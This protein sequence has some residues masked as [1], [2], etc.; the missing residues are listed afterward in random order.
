MLRKWEY[1]AKRLEGEGYPQELIKIAQEF[2]SFLV[3][4]YPDE[5]TRPWQDEYAA[6][7][8]WSLERVAA[9]TEYCVACMIEKECFLCKFGKKFGHCISEGS[10]FGKFMELLKRE[11]E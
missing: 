1:I 6:I 5:F 8:F 2:D 11:N 3:E 4:T 10:L 9:S 7:R